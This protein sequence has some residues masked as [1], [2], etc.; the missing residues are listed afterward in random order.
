M[1]YIFPIFW[2]IFIISAFIPIYK[3][4]RIQMERYRL[5]QRL[6]K[7]R[8]SRV[9]TLIHRQESLNILGI[10]IVRYV[11]VEDSE[12]VLRAIR[13]TPDTLPIDLVLHTPGGLLL[14]AE[15]IAMALRR[16]KAKVTVLIPHY[17]MSGGTLI[18]LAADEITLDP[19]AVLGPVD[20]QLGEYPA[21]SILEAIKAKSIDEV[22]DKTLI[23]GDIARKAIRQVQDTVYC[24]LTE[25]MD[26]IKAKAIAE[27]LSEGRWTHDYPISVNEARALGLPVTEAMPGIIYDL[28]ELYPQQ[29]QRRPTVEYIPVPYRQP[30]SGKHGN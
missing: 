13:L 1:D 16:H 6:E 28:M 27:I 19:N 4:Q 3:Q 10:P 7:D 12:Q 24:L 29:A 15:Q 8:K 25:N 17:A 18:S 14:A 20:P 21:V 22:D 26:D 2:I 11:T 30:D 23:L 9:I 5:I